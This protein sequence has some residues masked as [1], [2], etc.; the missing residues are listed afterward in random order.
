MDSDDW[1]EFREIGKAKRKRNQQSST[2]ILDENNIRYDSLN[3]GVHLVVKHNN[4]I[5]DF[6]P[7]TGKYYVRGSQ[8]YKRG[9]YN[10]L[11]DIK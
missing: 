9:I 6:W 8:K 11:K 4:F 2:A 1:R 7:S 3:G 5:V 10:L